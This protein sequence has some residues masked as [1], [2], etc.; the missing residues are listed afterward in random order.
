MKVDIF[1]TKLIPPYKN[2]RMVHVNK[3]YSSLYNIIIRDTYACHYRHLFFSQFLIEII[4]GQYMRLAKEK[5]KRFRQEIMNNFLNRRLLSFLT[6]D[7]QASVPQNGSI[8]F[9]LNSCLYSGT[10]SSKMVLEPLT[11]H[12]HKVLI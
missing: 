7:L 5:E 9:N 12:P 11:P 8:M 3:L 1:G 2:N 10:P 6:L 4:P